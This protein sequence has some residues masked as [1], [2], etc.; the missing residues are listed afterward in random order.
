[1][2]PPFLCRQIA[3]TLRVALPPALWHST[4]PRILPG[5]SGSPK[6]A[7]I[8]GVPLWENRGQ[9]EIKFM[10]QTSKEVL[11]KTHLGLSTEIPTKKKD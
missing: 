2:L 9:I 4:N 8:L 6:E 11:F 7:K 5:D 3:L 1:M 10:C